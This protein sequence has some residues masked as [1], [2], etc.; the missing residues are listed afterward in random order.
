MTDM[1]PTEKIW[2]NGRFIPWNDATIHVLSH[3]VSYGSSVFEGVRCYETAKGPAVFRLREHTR[4]LL[5]SSKIYRIPVDYTLDQLVSAQIELIQLNKLRSCYIRPIILRGYGGVGVLPV[6]NPT[7]IYLA[8]WEWGKYL[9]PEALA[10]GVDVCISSWTRIAPN[11]L[12]ALA[13]AG[14]NYMNSQLIRMEAHHNGYAEGIALDAN[15]CISEGSG[16]NL[17]VVRDG[18]IITPPLGSSV[19]PGITRDTVVTLARELGLEIVESV[20]PRELLYIADEVFFTGTAAEVTPIR[21]VDKIQIGAGRRGPITEKL[22][23]AFFDLVEGKAEDK[24]GWL[25][26]VPEPVTV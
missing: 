2:H 8:C 15:G 7:E 16:E 21:S 14:A 17:F 19:L 10:E 26:P 24:H 18:K 23:T 9:G 6:N 5:D 12:P 1:T 3:V 20:I 13:K 25:T 22:Q 4:R 11:T